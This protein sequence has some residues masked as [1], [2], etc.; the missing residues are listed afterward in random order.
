MPRSSRHLPALRDV[1]DSQ[2]GLITAAQLAEIGLHSG[3]ASRRHA[4]GMWTRVMPGVHLVDGGTP[5]RRQRELAALQYAGTPSALTGATALRRYGV[6]AVRLQEVADD[7]PDRPEPVHLLVPHDRRRLSTGFAR[8]ERTRR[9][10]E[11]LV[12]RGGLVLAPPA[13]AAADSARRLRRAA[14]VVALVSEMV[15]RDLV[16]LA[17]LEI[18]LDD[19]SRRGSALLRAALRPIT[20]GARS[21]PEA[22]L[23][24]LLTAEA[25]PSVLYNAT[26][27]DEHRRFVAI[28]DVWLDDVGLAIEVDSV[29]HHAGV[30]GFA[31]T[32]RR[33]SRYAAAGVLVLSVLPA[34]LRDHP[35]RVLREVRAARKAAAARPRPSV[36]VSSVGLPSAGREGWR[37]GA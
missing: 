22:D 1:A 26:L 27:V 35:G 36:R 32:V 31:A 23:V 28:P 30:G 16:T 11:S 15:H 10:P 9:F 7:E 12:L 34:D 8:I 21:A 5:S 6:R 13:R 18:E 2:L 17:D 20:S 4:G 29:E 25:I 33:T 3:T 14:D 19:G 37:W 24:G